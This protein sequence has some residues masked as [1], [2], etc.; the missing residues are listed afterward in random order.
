MSKIFLFF[1]SV[2]FASCAVASSIDKLMDYVSPNG[3]MINKNKAAIIQDQ[4]GGFA[5]G[6][7]ILLRGPSPKNLTPFNVQT[8][9]FSFDPCSGSGDFRFGAMSYITSEEFVNF[10]K[11]LGNASGAY[12]AKMAIKTLCPQ[13]EDIMSQLEGIA[14][15]INGLTMNQCAMAQKLVDGAFSKLS[16][17]NQQECMMRS[18]GK[19]T[20]LND[21]AR[22]CQ[23]NPDSFVG[24]NE[25]KM[26]SM[27]GKEFNLVWSALTSKGKTV[28]DKEFLELIMSISGT[29]I[30]K[31]KDDKWEFHREKSLF[32]KEEQIQGYIGG[33]NAANIKLYVC[34]DT[35][36]CMKPTISDKNMANK[37]FMS[38]VEKIIGTL[39]TKIIEDAKSETLSAEEQDLISFSTVPLIRLIED[40]IIFKGDTS[41]V[42]LSNPELIETIAY[43]CVVNF[44]HNL[45]DKADQ[46]VKELELGQNDQEVFRS[47]QTDI[48]SVKRS[49][50]ELKITSFSRA[51]IVMNVKD[52]MKLQSKSL[53]SRL[54][55]I[56]NNLGDE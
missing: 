32:T 48:T 55:K 34:D 26:G 56:L 41:S 6:G 3:T 33:S 23:K 22:K 38:R 7:S 42:L 47:F 40:D 50:S 37:T 24:N 49:L 13:C 15:D 35:T 30:G 27:L 4:S 9:S 39:T 17:A 20:D 44:L 12:M 21:A 45:L 10:F 36:K 16:G 11:N 5:T 43:D 25:D 8:P 31:L 18:K 1:I 29:I 54:S 2:F 46:A 53:D 51:Q 19:V 52:S 28:E 14:R